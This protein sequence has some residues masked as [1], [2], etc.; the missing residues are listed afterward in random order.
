MRQLIG[1]IVAF[2]IVLGLEKQVYTYNNHGL[3]S[4]VAAKQ[5]A[6][7]PEQ[8]KID[9]SNRHLIIFITNLSLRFGL[10]RTTSYCFQSSKN[11]LK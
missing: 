10:F 3:N 4:L 5:K 11:T 9:Y 7:H 6:S 2:G 8:N 1:L